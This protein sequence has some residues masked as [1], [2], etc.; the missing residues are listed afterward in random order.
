[1]V[2]LL[3]VGCGPLIEV[4][5][6]H[7]PEVILP[8]ASD[9]VGW[10]ARAG[11]PAPLAEPMLEAGV[12]RLPAVNDET[13]PCT[14]PVVVVLEE[15]IALQLGDSRQASTTWT[16]WTCPGP[17][18]LDRTSLTYELPAG[19]S[20]DADLAAAVGA[21]QADRLREDRGSASRRLYSGHPLLAEGVRLATVADW[22]GAT[23]AWRRALLSPR[24]DVQA[25]AAYDLAVAAELSGRPAEARHWAAD[26]ASLLDVRRT[27]SYLAALE[28]GEQ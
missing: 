8:V 26:A 2:A 4:Q 28:P 11:V 13:P 22:D 12:V 23:A 20:T 15:A 9:Q 14:T 18:L 19:A 25:K 3:L 1:M 16:T 21:V 6:H 5:W 27:R 7:P 24:Q 10:A 17:V